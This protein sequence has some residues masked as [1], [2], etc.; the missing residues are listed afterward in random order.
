MTAVKGRQ[1]I[2]KYSDRP[3]EDDVLKRVLEAA[4]HSPSANNK[5]SW[6]FIAVRDKDTIAKLAEA[7]GGQEFVG[8][9]PAILVS[10]GTEPDGVMMCGQHRYTVDLSIATAYMILAAYELGLGTC[11]LG[12]FNE[13]KVKEILN[14]PHEM[15]VVAMAPLGYPAETPPQMSRKDFDSVVCFEKY[16]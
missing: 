8:R 7:T 3:I 1:S 14:I 4:R 5:Q 2:R 15:R 11:W 10:C 16:Y 13:G 6:K 12:R 9:A